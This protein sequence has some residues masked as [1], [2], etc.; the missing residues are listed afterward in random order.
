MSRA[1]LGAASTCD[2]CERHAE[3]VYRIEGMDCHDEV[4][5]LERRLKHVPGFEGLTADVVNQRLWVRYDAAR[6]APA[7]LVAAIAQTGMRAWLHHERPIAPLDGASRRRLLLVVA[8]GITLAA[9]LALDHAGL[10]P[11]AALLAFLA[12]IACGSALT[13]RRAI[14]AAR[15]FS[16]D[17]NVLMLVAV[18]GA[19]A[20]GQWSEAATV[21]FLFALAQWLET[22]SMERTRRAI[23]ELMDLAPSEALVRRGGV[24]R[25]VK[26]D[27][28]EVGETLVVRPG[29][30]IPLDGRIVAGTSQINQA[31]ITGESLPVEKRAGDEVFAGTINGTGA[32]EIRVTRIGH[33]TTLGRIISLVEMAQAQRAPAQAFVERFARYY[34][35]AVILL[36]AA[37]A[38]GPPALLGQPFTPWVYRALVLLVIACPCALVISTPVSIVSA[39]AGAARKGVLIKGGLHLER[40]GTVSCVALDK[41]GT[42][43]SGRP[44]VVDVVALNGAGPP[45]V[46]R[47]AAALEAR[48]EHPIADAIL[49]YASAAGVSAPAASG[50]QALPGLGAEATVG[51]CPVLVGNH[52]LFAERGLLSPRVD[53]HLERLG[54]AGQT[55]VLVAAGGTTIGVVGVADRTR[56]NARTAVDQ[57]RRDGIGRVVMLT[58]DNLNT[59]RAIAADLGVDE[60]RAELLPADK[61]K[62]IAALRAEH[63][64]VA[65]VGDGVNDAPALAAADLGIA[66]GAAGSDAALETADVVLMGD[67]LLKIPYV[68]RLGRATVRNV[69]TNVAFS[70]ALKGAFL[71]LGVA[72]IAT[73]WMAV[74]A[75]MGASL[76]VIANGLRLLRA[77]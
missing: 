45:E 64:T 67:D 13:M 24:E 16:L 60:F 65:M 40:A 73:L 74:V 61:V 6:L 59:A 76:L 58:G 21:I 1:G 39:L 47:Y 3:S 18:G 70:L 54:Q 43:T 8:S 36:A 9:G 22:R 46:L 53:D 41:T 77:D 42:V 28:L 66:M 4:A 7:D 75:D 17:I 34:T 71:A 32:L 23:R 12:A 69:K 2:V 62:A 48:S 26:V 33:D 19:I 35:P 52:R 31:P 11:A 51:G 5:V 63:G 72:G 10:W 27:D 25:R 49:R 15:A 20:L 44:E 29:E 57:L 14:A 55:A 38:V 30:K 56:A 68:L 50:F 37:V